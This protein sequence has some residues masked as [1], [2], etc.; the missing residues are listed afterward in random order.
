MGKEWV[1]WSRTGEKWQK[2][3][4]AQEWMKLEGDVPPTM[5]HI[6]RKFGQKISIKTRVI[7]VLSH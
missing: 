1:T 4:L 3:K 2:Y 5:V 6:S 7:D